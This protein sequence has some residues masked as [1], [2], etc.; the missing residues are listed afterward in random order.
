MYNRPNQ[1]ASQI[2]DKNVYKYVIVFLA[3]L[4]VQ[5]QGQMRQSQ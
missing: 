3:S 5:A 4:R 2:I 1:N